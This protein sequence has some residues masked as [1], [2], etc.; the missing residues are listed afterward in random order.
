MT[1]DP[2]IERFLGAEG[3][4][5][6][7]AMRAGLAF[8]QDHDRATLLAQVGQRIEAVPAFDPV[9]KSALQDSYGGNQPAPSDDFLVG[10]GLLYLTEQRRL[11]LDCTSGHYQMLWGYGHPE[12]GAAIERATRAGIVWDNHSNIPQ[13]PVKQLARRLVALANAPNEPDPLDTV[14]LGVCTGSVACAAALK[15]QLQ[16]FERSRGRETTPVI[17]TLEGNYHGTDMVPQILRGMWPHLAQPFESAALAPNDPAALEQ[18]FRRYGERVAGFWAEPVMMNREAIAIEP[19]YLEQVRQECD[20]VGA[21]LCVDEIQTGFWRPEIFDYRA[22]RIQPDLV[23]LGK[24][25]TCG[26]HPHSAVLM[27]QRHDVLAQYDAISTNGSAALPCYAALA[28]LELIEA[29]AEAIRQTADRIQAGFQKLVREFPEWLE[30]AQ[31]RGH[32]AGLKFHRVE[33]AITFH[34]RAVAAGLWCRVHAYHAGHSTVLTK[35]GLLADAR[36]VDYVLDRFAA[37]LKAGLR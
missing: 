37:L 10:Q 30:A 3:P 14:L 16:V 23:V 11:F 18:A 20:R 15:I 22:L 33:E 26:F 9:D 12:L 29:H 5:V 7:A 4:G 1:T 34:R 32:L 31:G 17:L 24:G 21:L 25:M 8:L 27:K 35:L 2:A 36:T 6:A 28:S 19:T 13:W